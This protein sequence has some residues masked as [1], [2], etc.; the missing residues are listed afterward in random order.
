[1]RL[2]VDVDARGAVEDDV[3]L[4][5]AGSEGL[6]PLDRVALHD[7]DGPRRVL[8]LVAAVGDLAED[9]GRQTV[10]EVDPAEHGDEVGARHVMAFHS[11]GR[12]PRG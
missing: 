12:C 2:P 1:M 5:A 4:G 10:E 11:I 9:L 3:H 7:H 8:G 6:E